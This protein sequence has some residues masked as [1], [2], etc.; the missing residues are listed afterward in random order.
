MSSADLFKTADKDGSGNLTLAEYMHY[1][2]YTQG[3]P[4]DPEHIALHGEHFMRYVLT[5][6]CGDAKCNDRLIICRFDK[7]GDGAVHFDEHHRAD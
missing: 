2:S 7:I 3:A 4:T 5:S 6:G 1:V